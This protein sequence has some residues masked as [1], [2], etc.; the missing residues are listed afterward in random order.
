MR[1]A[2]YRLRRWMWQWCRAGTTSERMLSEEELRLG[3]D[4]LRMAAVHERAA[5]DDVSTHAPAAINASVLRAALATLRL[6]GDGKSIANFASLDD[7]QVWLQSVDFDRDGAL[8][9]SDLQCC[10]DNA[11]E[12]GDE[13][14]YID[15]ARNA[16]SGFLSLRDALFEKRLTVLSA[17]REIVGSAAQKDISQMSWS[18]GVPALAPAVSAQQIAAMGRTLLNSSS[19]SGSALSIAELRRKLKGNQVAQ[20]RHRGAPTPREI[21]TG[22]AAAVAGIVGATLSFSTVSQLVASIQALGPSSPHPDMQHVGVGALR[23]WLRAS[24]CTIEMSALQ[25]ALAQWTTTAS[26]GTAGSNGIAVEQLLRIVDNVH[27]VSPSG[28]DAVVAANKFRSAKRRVEILAL[29]RGEGL[30]DGLF[31]AFATSSRSGSGIAQTLMSR[32]QF[33]C[34]LIHAGVSLHSECRTSLGPFDAT[35]LK[36]ATWV[37]SEAEEGGGEGEGEGVLALTTQDVLTLFHSDGADMRSTGFLNREM[38]GRACAL[39]TGPW[40][41][42]LFSRGRPSVRSG[43]T[44]LPPALNGPL[45]SIA[46]SAA[47]ELLSTLLQWSEENDVSLALMHRALD[48]DDD[49]FVSV[50]DL[51]RAARYA[52]GVSFGNGKPSSARSGTRMPSVA[53]SATEAAL[54]TA[55][56]T[57]QEA[58]LRWEAAKHSR[59]EAPLRS[60]IRALFQML[61]N[62]TAADPTLTEREAKLAETSLRSGQVTVERWTAALRRSVDSSADVAFE[63]LAEYVRGAKHGAASTV[64]THLFADLFTAARAGKLAQG[65]VQRAS[66]ASFPGSS[67]HV[68]KSSAGA[69]ASSAAVVARISREETLSSRDLALGFK[70]VVA[71]RSKGKRALPAPPSS[72]EI[73]RLARLLGSSDDTCVITADAFVAALSVQ[74]R[75]SGAQAWSATSSAAGSAPDAVTAPPSWAAVTTGLRALGRLLPTAMPSQLTLRGATRSVEVLFAQD[76]RSAEEL[77]EYLVRVVGADEHARTKLDLLLTTRMVASLFAR[78]K[79]SK[80]GR[81]DGTAWAFAMAPFERHYAALHHLRDIVAAKVASSRGTFLRLAAAASPSKGRRQGGGFSNGDA[82]QHIT[83]V[84]FFK[85]LATQCAEEDRM[86]GISPS[87]R[88][89]RAAVDASA[90]TRI[91]AQTDVLEVFGVETSEL[92]CY[93]LLAQAS[94]S[95][96]DAMSFH[97]F[98]SLFE[99]PKVA[100]MKIDLVA[101]SLVAVRKALHAALRRWRL[102]SAKASMRSFVAMFG[103]VCDGSSTAALFASFRQMVLWLDPADGLVAGE[104]GGGGRGSSEAALATPTLLTLVATRELF[105]ALKRGHPT[106]GKSRAAASAKRG[107][108]VRNE[109]SADVACATMEVELE[110]L[111]RWFSESNDGERAWRERVALR[112]AVVRRLLRTRFTT[113]TEAFCGMG[114]TR[115]VEAGKFGGAKATKARVK[116]VT[117]AAAGALVLSARKLAHGLRELAVGCGYCPPSAAELGELCES[118]TLA[119]G[120]LAPQ[121]LGGAYHVDHPKTRLDIVHFCNVFWPQRQKGRRGGKAARGGAKRAALVQQSVR[122]KQMQ[123]QNDDEFNRHLQALMPRTLAAIHSHV[124]TVSQRSEMISFSLFLL[125]LLLTLYPHSAHTHTHAAS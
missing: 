91:T 75:S 119:A 52:A 43:A 118:A 49:G 112:H 33:A 14:A 121:R 35:T 78:I 95:G 105:L 30:A 107:I 123:A 53:L 83:R 104:G 12:D 110:A 120:I 73:E 69:T 116:F 58:P 97:T 70:R 48:Q 88:H 81:I 111:V 23:R 10:V 60:T 1:T 36:F 74:N 27:D 25:F 28:T 32:S 72:V 96:S 122:A 3:Y 9:F 45:N 6:A 98:N 40:A 34:V 94:A 8:S 20:A 54:K 46:K 57:L 103:C 55:R 44:V 108:T 67:S 31:D 37:A 79:C 106:L 102:H 19:A 62:T 124:R 100:A 26:T 68:S 87:G 22:V 11:A 59:S 64:G 84:S 71:A 82:P 51:V 4:Q 24:G 101:D 21:R 109:P 117:E 16:A 76:L 93:L 92:W 89:A 42:L 77:R 85:A 63:Q 113:A 2:R 17:V 80:S 50:E 29:S 13:G 114:A 15:E 5:G 41:H 47:M 65:V 7:A 39:P 61:E 18:A 38:F 99:V 90:R 86:L 56:R 125:H 115:N 66:I